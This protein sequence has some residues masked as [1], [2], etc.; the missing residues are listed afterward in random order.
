MDKIGSCDCTAP[1]EISLERFRLLWSELGAEI[2]KSSK[3]EDSDTVFVAKA[4]EM[5]KQAPEKLLQCS[6]GAEEKTREYGLPTKTGVETYPP[7]VWEQVK[8]FIDS[9]VWDCDEPA[10]PSDKDDPLLSSKLPYGAFML[11]FD[12]HITPNGPKLIEVNTNAGGLATALSI[13]GCNQ[14]EKTLLKQQ[15]VAAL[16]SEYATASGKKAPR[17]MVIVDENPA[18]QGLYAE[19]LHFAKLI[20][21]HLRKQPES[22]LFQCFVCDPSE[23]VVDES[24][25]VLNFKDN[26][27]NSFP[28]DL[29]YNR[30]TDFRFEEPA[31]QH[32]RKA[33]LANTLVVTPH[34]ASYVRIADKRLLPLMVHNVVPTTVSLS[35][36]PMEYW[37]KNKKRYV[38]KPASGNASKGVYR[39]D[40][41]SIAKL[42]GLP[43]EETL[44]QEY[45]PPGESDDG[46]KYDLRVYTSGGKILGVASRQF[47]GQVMEMRSANSGFRAALPENVCCFSALTGF[48]SDDPPPAKCC[49]SK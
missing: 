20:E 6:P 22:R 2:E 9:K 29:M 46:S 43:L 34:P 49:G 37:E 36:K 47:T 4:I 21:E 23:L 27:G 17:N 5:L 26:S 3:S 44:A 1:A 7:A 39:G 16:L 19:M 48:F 33:C 30:L 41:I 25:G 45:C 15:W 31:N 28:V 35:S 38:F 40:K 14:F 13:G 32:I 12:F 42:K 8:D 24:S 10:L 11:G 18:E